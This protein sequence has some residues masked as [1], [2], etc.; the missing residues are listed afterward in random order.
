MAVD[1]AVLEELSGGAVRVDGEKLSIRSAAV[2][3]TGVIAIADGSELVME[4]ALAHAMFKAGDSGVAVVIAP[5]VLVAAEEQLERFVWLRDGKGAEVAGN[6][7]IA[8]GETQWQWTPK[9]SWRPGKYYLVID[10][11]LEDRAA[12]SIARPFEVDLD[13]PREESAATIEL[14]IEIK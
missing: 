12:N 11:R 10:T 8:S 1:L 6:L 7:E 13:K 5:R 9:V 3:L 14:A 4:R 2:E